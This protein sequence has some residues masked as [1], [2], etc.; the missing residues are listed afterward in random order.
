M[1]KTNFR[2]IFMG[3]PFFAVPTLAALIARGEKIVGVIT[4]PDR[5]KGRGRK[6]T[7]PP[8][9]EAAEQAG[10]AVYQPIKIK[11]ADFMATLQNLAPDLIV[12]VA[13]GRILPAH[14][15]NLPTHGTIN[16]HAS[17]LPKYRGAA[18]IQ[19]A[20]IRGETETGV[21]I[22]QMDEGMDTGDIMLTRQLPINQDDNAATLT[23]K[24]ADLGS[25]ALVEA[26][27]LL[28]TGRLSP[29]R[30]DDSLATPAPPL[31]KAEGRVD[32]TKPAH[33]ISGLIR[34][35]D[36]W[37]S[38]YT[39]LAGKRLRLFAPQVVDSDLAARQTGREAGQPTKPG[40]LC[41]ADANGL[42]IATGKDYLLIQE[43]QP[44]G[45]KRMSADAYLRGHILTAGMIFE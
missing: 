6:L 22:M 13:Y 11:G 33:A 12:V 28:R 16:V 21:T 20:L 45:S 35:L 31:C 7:P 41:H 5:P 15:I 29:A 39:T 42:L 24:L 19:W 34:G 2:I 27:D 1:A 26:L 8:V 40:T 32:W 17:L 9:K 23:K 3:T 18:P 30:Q 44:E 25:Q 43:L 36:P 37:P 10:L 38:S 4:Q 14:I